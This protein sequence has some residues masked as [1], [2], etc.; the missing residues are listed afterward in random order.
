LEVVLDMRQFSG[1]IAHVMV[2]DEG[3]CR[4][5]ITICIAAPFLG[6]ELIADEIAQCFRTRGILSPPDDIVEIIKK[7]LI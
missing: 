3:D 2:V 5:R 1:E 6:D 7:M 4:D